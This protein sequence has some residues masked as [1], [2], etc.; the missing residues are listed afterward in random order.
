FGG[1]RH[2]AG[3]GQVGTGADQRSGHGRDPTRGRRLPARR[4]GGRRT[5]RP[6]PDARAV[7]FVNFEDRLASVDARDISFRVYGPR[8]GSPVVLHNGTPGTRLLAPLQVSA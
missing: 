2:A 5:W 4:G 8:G 7:A 1:R 6:D 3:R